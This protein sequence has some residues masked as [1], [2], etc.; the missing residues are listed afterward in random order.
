MGKAYES[1]LNT[2]LFKYG[3]EKDKKLAE[4]IYKSEQNAKVTI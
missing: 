4:Y 3:D 1:Y 2:I